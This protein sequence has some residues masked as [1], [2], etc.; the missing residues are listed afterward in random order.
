MVE[1]GVLVLPSLNLDLP[2]PPEDLVVPADPHVPSP[3]SPDPMV[4][5]KKLNPTTA[6]ARDGNLGV[7][8][9]CHELC[10]QASWLL[11]GYIRVNNQSTK[12][13]SAS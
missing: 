7:G 8:S 3:P 5:D 13:R 2:A 1:C 4:V 9:H 11:I 12:A 10:Q 6:K